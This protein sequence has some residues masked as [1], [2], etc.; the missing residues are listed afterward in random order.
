MT[1]EDGTKETICQ[2][3]TLLTFVKV[4]Y[5]FYLQLFGKVR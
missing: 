2:N 4:D 3:L 5:G 1:A